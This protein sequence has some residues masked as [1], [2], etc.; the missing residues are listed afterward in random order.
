MKKDLFGL[1]CGFVLNS[2]EKMQ[3]AA[4]FRYT[5]DVFKV[6]GCICVGVQGSEK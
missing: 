3:F 2:T 4:K 5:I 6:T 1:I